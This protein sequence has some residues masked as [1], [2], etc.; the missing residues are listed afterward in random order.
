MP[1][2][3]S[4]QTTEQQLHIVD[5][6]ACALIIKVQSI[7]CQ[8]WKRM[9][10]KKRKEYG[11]SSDLGNTVSVKLQLIQKKINLIEINFM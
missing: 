5:N 8:T 7:I 10:L 3:V 6:L 2:M 11:G 1:K 4:A 9:V